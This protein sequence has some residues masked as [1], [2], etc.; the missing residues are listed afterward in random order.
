MPPRAREKTRE[1][2]DL[3]MKTT[4]K[5]PVQGLGSIILECPSPTLTQDVQAC[6]GLNAVSGKEVRAE[7]NAIPHQG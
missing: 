7:T 2:D 5:P 6:N 3:S 1:M 4:T